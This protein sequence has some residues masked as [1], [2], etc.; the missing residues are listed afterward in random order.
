[1]S[2]YNVIF[3]NELYHHGVKG[4][5][6]GI[7]R[8]QN[9]DG[10]L[11]PEGRARLKQDIRGKDAMMIPKGQT[12]Y[13]L[14]TN[15]GSDAK[16]DKMYVNMDEQGRD[17]YMREL[18]R[19]R[20]AKEGKAFAQ[21]Y[22]AKNDIIMPGKKELEKIEQGLLNDKAVR[23]EVVDSLVRK[24]IKREEADK[25]VKNW[26]AGRNFA[27]GLGGGA[28]AG[29][30][31][32]ADGAMLGVAGGP[33]GMAIGAAIGGLAVGAFV[34]ANTGKSAEDDYYRVLRATY[35][36]KE[37]KALNEA[38]RKEVTKRGYNAI[39]DYNDWRAYGEQG[40]NAM[41]IF[42]SDKNVQL[43]SS[44]KVDADVY[45][46]GYTGYQRQMSPRSKI[47]DADYYKDG[48]AEYNRLVDEYKSNKGKKAKK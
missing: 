20:I 3:S 46:K 7:R 39:R 45:A 29:L 33:I 2:N 24:G 48:V 25:M 30:M 40:K 27:K 18:G 14:S 42:D 35:G 1:M 19:T 31:G 26:S 21:E 11:T 32:A 38:L 10:S 12:F 17:F 23:K 34:G 4:Q 5:K 44:K 28:A 6:W 16:G 22:V 9:P 13:R 8:Y 47:E 36:D 37:S 15:K 43:K 41:I